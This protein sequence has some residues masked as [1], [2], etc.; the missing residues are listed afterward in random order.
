[1]VKLNQTNRYIKKLN[2][3]DLANEWF[4][5]EQRK[6]MKGTKEILKLVNKELDFRKKKGLIR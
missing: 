6:N 4:E 5:L 3:R 1:M 2:T